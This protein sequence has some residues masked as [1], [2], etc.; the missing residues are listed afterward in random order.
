M[1][2]IIF[3]IADKEYGI[4]INQVYKVIR[5]NDVT[6][7]PDSAEFVEGVINLRGRVIPI[8]SLRK[9][10]KMERADLNKMNRVIVVRFNNKFVGVIVDGVS[11][12]LPIQSSN[13]IEPDELLKETKYLIGVG[14]LKERLIL[15]I[16]IERLLSIG[17]RTDIEEV[18][19]KLIFQN[20]AMCSKT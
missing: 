4:D 12:I 17:E 18:S 14:R 10:L 13:I 1:T 15:I 9:K 3:A 8:I 2:L 11:E 19:K 20:S 6:T 7:I 16:D 5:V